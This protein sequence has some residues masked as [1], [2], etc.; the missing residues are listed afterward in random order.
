M[1]IR[2]MAIGCWTNF[3]REDKAEVHIIDLDL[4]S[5]SKLYKSDAEQLTKNEQVNHLL[6]WE[7]M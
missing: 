5:M 6:D 3:V 1:Y 2:E 4:V 7:K